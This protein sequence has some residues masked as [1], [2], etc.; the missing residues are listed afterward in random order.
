MNLAIKTISKSLP[1]ALKAFR[2]AKPDVERFIAN[3][4]QYL[5]HID[6][7]E[8]EENLK[9]HLMGLLKPTFTP[10]H[11]IEQYGDVDFVI[12]TG[13]K[14]TRP[15]VLFEAKREANKTDMIRTDD[16]NRKA[17]HGLDLSRFRAAPSARL[18]HL[19]FESDRAFP[20]QC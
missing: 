11:I 19:S 9:T 17:L 2:P 5:G 15:G 18:S 3:L 4:D 20:A 13:G 16:I 7:K 10:T 1:P 6:S 14:G 8:T 12:R